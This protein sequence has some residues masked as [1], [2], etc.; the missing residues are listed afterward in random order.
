[1]LTYSTINPKEGATLSLSAIG[2][3]GSE[4]APPLAVLYLRGG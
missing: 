3:E 2:E 1:M 4:G